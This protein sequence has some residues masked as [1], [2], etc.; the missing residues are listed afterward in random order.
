MLN[1]YLRKLFRA[2]RRQP[3]AWNN[4]HLLG[5]SKSEIAFLSYSGLTANGAY[6]QRRSVKQFYR[7]F[8]R[9]YDFWQRNLFGHTGRY[10]DFRRSRM[11]DW[12]CDACRTISEIFERRPTK[13][14]FLM[15]ESTG[16]TV[17]VIAA[18]LFQLFRSALGIPVFRAAV[19]SD[20]FQRTV[21]NARLRYW[22][23]RTSY[24]L[25]L[26]RAADKPG[27]IATVILVVPAFRLL[28]RKNEILL[29]SCL[30]MYYFA[31]LAGQLGAVTLQPWLWPIAL[32]NYVL[33][34]HVFARIW[35][36]SGNAFAEAEGAAVE[37]VV[38]PRNQLL[39]VGCCF[40][41][42]LF[43]IA[44]AAM[45]WVDSDYGVYVMQVVYMGFL[46]P[47]ALFSSGGRYGRYDTDLEL[48]FSTG[49]Y[50]LP[51]I[52]TATLLLLQGAARLAI[53]Y[54]R[55]DLIVVF[56]GAD[57]VVDNRVG[58][59]DIAACPAKVKRVV[60][61]QGFEHAGWSPAQ[62][63][64]FVAETAS[65]LMEALDAHSKIADGNAA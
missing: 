1:G 37:Q 46:L 62:Q 49:Y 64:R 15:G 10:G 16:A 11:W 34:L 30:V 57:L 47:P 5:E 65:Q 50:W 13:S 19:R 58:E 27:E 18:F 9:K 42:G 22:L 29:A 4:L 38:Q 54:L 40:F 20:A 26:L 60:H 25:R 48:P 59:R 17:I 39:I 61:L 43:P 32:A 45:E 8:G 35:I 63:D 7:L 2:G 3:R 33:F 55:T 44:S 41:Y 24:L 56:A 36:P 6:S 28:D 12:V 52:T 21:S 53:R 51:V 31:A 14:L 23:P